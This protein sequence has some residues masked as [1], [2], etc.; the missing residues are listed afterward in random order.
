ME[1]ITWQKQQ[2]RNKYGLSGVGED[3]EKNGLAGEEFP[4]Q[5]IVGLTSDRRL[6]LRTQLEDMGH[7]VVATGSHR[8]FWKS[9]AFCSECVLEC[10][11]ACRQLVGETKIGV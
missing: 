6:D 4:E 3:S 1:V 5:E 2:G 9:T 8:V 11:V 10:R 7:N